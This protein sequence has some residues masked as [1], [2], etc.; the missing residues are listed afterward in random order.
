MMKDLT[1][2][3]GTMTEQ[4]GRGELSPDQRLQMARRM[5]R[6]SVMMRRM[7][8]LAALPTTKEADQKPQM[9]QMRKETD[10]TMLDSRMTPHG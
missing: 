9:Q 6:M 1:Q 7:S 8:G 10:E 4:M 2:E 5:E 3:M